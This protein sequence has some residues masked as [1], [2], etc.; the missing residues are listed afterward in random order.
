MRIGKIIVLLI[1]FT[2]IVSCSE[3]SKKPNVIYVFAD[4]WRAQATGFAG[5][6]N[7]KTPNLDQLAQEGINF[8][9]AVSTCPSCTPYRASLL[10]GLYTT[11]N[12]LLLNDILLDPDSESMAK[13]YKK[14]GYNT[15]YWGKWHI[16]GPYRLAYISEEN[17]Q[18][19]D[20]WKVME[21]THDYMD[22]WYY[23]GNDRSR[24]KWDGYDAHA[25]AKDMCKYIADHADD[26]NPFLA[27]LSWGPP[28]DPYFQI[29]EKYLKMYEDLTKIVLRENVPEDYKEEAL[30]MLQ[31]YY[32]HIAALDESMGWIMDQIK[33]SGIEDNTILIFTSDHGD[34][35][36][37]RGMKYKSNPWDEA[38][39]VP[40]LLKYPNAIK[41]KRTIE[42]PIGTP[43]ILPT[44]LGLSKIKTDTKFEGTD[45]SAIVIGEQDEFDNAALITN[46]TKNVV[47]KEFRGVRTSRYT[48]VE[49]LNGPWLLYDNETDPYQFTNLIEMEGNDKLM[50][51]LKVKLTGEL[52]KA[53]D[54]FLPEQDYLERFGIYITPG[55][56]PPMNMEYDPNK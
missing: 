43:D 6:V 29:P 11:T 28:H 33:K 45:F 56:Y 5:D 53:N 3:E 17:R 30:K 12:G 52:K 38:I 27:V 41:E 24:K 44:L 36:G 1:A 26:D 54:E 23:D 55:G 22:S 9:N 4:Q 47:K 34:M 39:M 13:I 32:A 18:G 2:G 7:A 46:P 25:Q 21:C 19:F 8:V 49:D 50:A 37:S 40:F 51:E 35:V 15:A 14:A 42:M 10:T 16:G 31:G 20:Y 48:Y